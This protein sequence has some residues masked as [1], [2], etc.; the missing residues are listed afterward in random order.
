M[1]LRLTYFISTSFLPFFFLHS[2]P[3]FHIYFYF[4]QSSCFFTWLSSYSLKYTRILFQV[5]TISLC[6][7]FLLIFFL[8]FQS[9]VSDS[10]LRS[11]FFDTF[12]RPA[13]LL[14]CY[15]LTLSPFPFLTPFSFLLSFLP[16]PLSPSKNP[17]PSSLHF[18]SLCPLIYQQFSLQA[19][20]RS[21]F[22]P[23]QAI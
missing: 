9:V 16:S 22:F 6:V 4:T 11:R 5:L 17:P 13:F 1:L 20:P 23:F 7:F 21:F 12:S 15:C 10:R 19:S 14:H 18:L 3:S 8:L 2:L